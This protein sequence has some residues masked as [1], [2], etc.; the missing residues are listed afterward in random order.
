MQR[1]YGQRIADARGQVSMPALLY[2]LPSAP[3]QY[4]CSPKIC[5][6]CLHVIVTREALDV[7]CAQLCQVLTMNTQTHLFLKGAAAGH[8]S[9]LRHWNHHASVICSSSQRYKTLS[10]P[11]VTLSF[12]STPVLT[13]C[14]NHAISDTKN[15]HVSFARLL[16]FR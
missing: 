15:V 8:P 6:A 4:L 11:A 3:Q 7:M 12:I 9:W 2:V 16:A 10:R 1:L 13:S 5:S 14:H